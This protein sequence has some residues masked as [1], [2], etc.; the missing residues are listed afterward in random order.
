MAQQAKA[1]GLKRVSRIK[2]KKD[3]DQSS[4]VQKRLILDFAERQRWDL[5]ESR[6]LDENEAASRDVSGGA[7]PDAA[8]ASVQRFG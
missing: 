1:V 3:S 7:D 2:K 5:P 4:E 8:R 6:L